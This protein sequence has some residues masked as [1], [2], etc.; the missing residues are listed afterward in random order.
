MTLHLWIGH[1]SSWKE[2]INLQSEVTHDRTVRDKW[3]RWSISSG[4]NSKSRG[5]M[6]QT[7]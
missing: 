4:K 3:R 5:N 6:P 1:S 7:N 2:P